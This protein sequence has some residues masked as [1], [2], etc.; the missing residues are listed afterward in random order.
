MSKVTTNTRPVPNSQSAIGQ[1]K[2]GMVYL[3]APWISFFQQFTQKA[4]TI[5]DVSSNSPYKP[6]QTGTIIITGGTGIILNR[7]DININLANGQAVIPMAIG[8][9]LSWTAGT[10][11]FL[12]S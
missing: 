8:D 2:D 4:A 10:V 9:T 5:V 6:N 3:V 11:K 7:G 12:G 1:V